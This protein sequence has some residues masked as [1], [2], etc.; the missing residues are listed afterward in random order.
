MGVGVGATRRPS[1]L[2][3]TSRRTAISTA[4]LRVSAPFVVL[5]VVSQ[6]SEFLAWV[7]VARALTTAEVG[8]L[9]MAYLVCRY[10]GIAA[11]WGA[12][13]VGV[14]LVAKS[15]DDP[16][17][18][19]LQRFREVLSL[20]LAATLA[21]GLA[22]VA[23]ST[24]PLALVA[25]YRGANRDW[26]ALGSG[27]NVAAGVP[28][29]LAGVGTL[30]SAM[31]AGTPSAFATGTGLSFVVAAGVSIVA[32]PL[33]GPR[34]RWRSAFHAGGWMVVVVLTDQLYVSSDVLLLGALRSADD[35]G[36]YSTLYRFPSA[37]LALVALVSHGWLRTAAQETD[38]PRRGVDLAERARRGGAAAGALVLASTPFIWWL[39][40]RIL[41]PEFSDHRDVLVILMLGAALAT[42]A[43]PLST[44]YMTRHSDQRLAQVSLLI[45]MLNLAGNLAAIPVAGMAGAAATTAA[46]YM[47]LA[48]FYSW[49]LN[50]STGSGRTVGRSFPS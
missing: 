24:T 31:V 21:L 39:V 42:F 40:P 10:A 8:T 45:G 44:V 26:I 18:A 5:R 23:P 1:D 7:V 36:V 4:L 16:D 49:S 2:T 3:V 48:G 13:F 35:A 20:G 47:L 22:I 25:L 17:V 19:G 43:A 6:G 28:A 9:A 27:R 12:P 32:N 14:R 33:Q 41:P 50:R 34:S 29:F 30:T 11:D 46:S 37:L 15:P 38:D